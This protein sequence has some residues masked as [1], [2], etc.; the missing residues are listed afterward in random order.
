MQI[1]NVLNNFSDATLPKR[2]ESVE[3][4]DIAMHEDG[5]QF[6]ASFAG[7]AEAL[8][9]I[10]SQYDV[11]DISPGQFSKMIQKLFDAGVL[12]DGEL[13]QLAVVRL[14]LDLAGMDADE[15]VDLLDFYSKKIDGI[16]RRADLSDD[17]PPAKDQLASLFRRLDWIEKFA[18]IQANPDS[19]GLNALV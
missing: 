4:A 5:Q 2:G 16:Q 1:S 15:S 3:S 17:V 12:S 7:R 10:L 19:T 13:Q 6:S 8:A 14:D 9:D 11:S 18:T